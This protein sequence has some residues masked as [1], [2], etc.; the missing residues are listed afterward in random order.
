MPAWRSARAARRWAEVWVSTLTHPKP[1]MDRGVGKYIYP[2]KKFNYIIIYNFARDVG[3]Y[4]RAHTLRN[5][6]QQ[7]LYGGHLWRFHVRPI[8]HF[9]NRRTA[10][11]NGCWQV[12]V[13]RYLPTYLPTYPH[14]PTVQGFGRFLCTLPAV[15]L[16]AMGG[17]PHTDD[18]QTRASTPFQN[19]IYSLLARVWEMNEAFF[20]HFPYPG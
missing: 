19:R 10:A 16:M 1:E 2:P 11:S 20:I 3:K 9:K 7:K 8:K 6:S 18:T 15:S 17:R 5:E 4:T 12:W 14:L 13:N